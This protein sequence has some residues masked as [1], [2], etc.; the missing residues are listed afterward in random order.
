MKKFL[1][2]TSCI[3]IR[4][5]YQHF[6]KSYFPIETR[7]ENFSKFSFFC[8][9]SWKFFQFFSLYI[10]QISK[11]FSESH[12]PLEV[13]TEINYDDVM[14]SLPDN[15]FRESITNR[16]FNFSKSHLPMRT[17]VRNPSQLWCRSL[18]NTFYK[19]N[20]PSER[21]KMPKMELT[22]PV[23]ESDRSLCNFSSQETLF[24]QFRMK[25]S[26]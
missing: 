25:I 2:S 9:R 22:Y 13:R 17:R 23:Q 10:A 24:R 11:L 20:I 12:P 6:F 26:Y 14:V 3:R 4:T 16:D 5:R 1:S 7:V 8:Y 19:K 21:H 18:S 15:A